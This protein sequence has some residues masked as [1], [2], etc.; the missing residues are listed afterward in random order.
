M[1]VRQHHKKVTNFFLLEIWQHYALLRQDVSSIQKFKLRMRF[2]ES[3]NDVLIFP[4]K[5]RARRVNMAAI[6]L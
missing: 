4:L 5:Y 1:A 6:T 3:L 2:Q